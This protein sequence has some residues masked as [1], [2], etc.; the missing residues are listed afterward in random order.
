MRAHSKSVLA[1]YHLALLC[2]LCAGGLSSFGAPTNIFS[3]QFELAQGYNP[4]LDLAGQNGWT[5][6]GSGGNGLTN[7]LF[8]GQGQQAYVGRF[9]PALGQSNLFVWRPINFSPVAAGLPLVTFTTLMSVV[10]STN[11]GFDFFQ[12]HVYNNQSQPLIVIDFDTD[13]TNVGYFVNGT[14]YVNTGVKFALGATYTLTVTMNFASNRWSATLN[15]ALLATDQPI[16]T[17]G[18][19]LTLGDVDAVWNIYLPAVP[20]NNFM[21]FDNYTVTADVLPPASPPRPGLF[22]PRY[23]H[24]FNLTFP[25]QS[26]MVYTVEFADRPQTSNWTAFTN[27]VGNGQIYVV[28][29]YTATNI[30]RYY[31]VRTQTGAARPT[32]V[33]NGLGKR[34]SFSLSTQAGAKYLVDGSPQLQTPVW[35]LLRSFTGDGSVMT[36]VDDAASDHARFY[37]VRIE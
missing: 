4:N 37:R 19:Q 18:K 33:A 14:D 30:A 21:L 3:T 24:S 31:R 22:A 20:G 23:G 36:F 9:P 13:T 15:S 1:G 17:T 10:G 16:T 26:N 28:R 35:T 12:W 32:V 8:G 6:F 11:D 27:L 7:G 29:D 34:F 5:K 2:F 25:T